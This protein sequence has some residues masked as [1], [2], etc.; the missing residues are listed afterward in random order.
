MASLVA[1]GVVV[2]WMREFDERSGHA[3]RT[4]VAGEVESIGIVDRIASSI[5]R[6]TLVA[7]GLVPE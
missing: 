6:T 7:E 5:G 1:E 3:G 2:V 4:E